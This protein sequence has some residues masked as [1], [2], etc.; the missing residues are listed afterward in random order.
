M[1]AGARDFIMKPVTSV[2]LSRSIHAVLEAEEKRRMRH[3]RQ[4]QS[5]PVE[6]TIIT[7]ASLKGGVGKSTTSVN[8]AIALRKETAQSVT[9]MDGEPNFGDVA[10]LLK[11]DD[12]NMRQ[13]MSYVASMS[14]QLDR[15]SVLD[16]MVPHHS[17]L[18]VLPTATYLESW[19][20]VNPADV[21]RLIS[22]IAQT[23]DYLVIDTPSGLNDISAAALESSLL[24]LL[25]TTPDI[26]SLKDTILALNLL[27]SWGVD[28]E[29]IKVVMNH[30]HPPSGV[31]PDDVKLVL[32]HDIFW[33]LPNDPLVQSASQLGQPIVVSYPDSKL[34]QSITG[35]ARLISGA[36]HQE[37]K[38]LI[39]LLPVW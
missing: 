22:L 2:D 29:R 12:V 23:Q 11:I 13:G 32:D 14:D 15:N 16:Y 33:T 8:L 28:K 36:K 20:E 7:V 1:L 4:T 9:L 37:R 35:L 19:Q 10:V 34:S 24:I 31:R 25:M 6:G 26:T 5:V 21:K 3:A 17:G 39:R 38:S 30:T 27:K 18:S